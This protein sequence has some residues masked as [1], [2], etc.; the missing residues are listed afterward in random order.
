MKVLS[1]GLVINSVGVI[2]TSFITF[3]TVPLFTN[4][5]GIEE[6][7][8]FT[9]WLVS[10]NL[11]QCLD[12]GL[13]TT[14]I[15]SKKK[16]GYT[17]NNYYIAKSFELVLFF[18]SVLFFFA[19]SVFNLPEGNVYER[20]IE[21]CGE[22]ALFL[23]FTPILLNNFVKFYS[24][25]MLSH[26]EMRTY[27]TFI[28]VNEFSKQIIGFLV[29]WYF[30]DWFYFFIYQCVASFCLAWFAK[31]VFYSPF[32]NKG[33]LNLRYLKA[34]VIKNY[35]FTL[36]IFFSSLAGGALS[37]IDR[38][39]LSA[40]LSLSSTGL[41]ASC[42]VVASVINMVVQPFHK[43]SMPLFVQLI[44]EKNELLSQ[45]FFSLSSL[46][47][48]I[49]V[50]LAF[51]LYYFSP[52]YIDIIVVD[53]TLHDLAGRIILMLGLSFWLISCG[54]LSSNLLQAK[55]V[56]S[57]QLWNIIMAVVIGGLIST[58]YISKGYVI[59]ATL[60]WLVHGV[61]QCTVLPINLSKRIK[62]VTLFAWYKNVLF[63]P[64]IRILLLFIFLETIVS[65]INIYVKILFT[66]LWLVIDF[67]FVI[68]KSV[69]KVLKN[70]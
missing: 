23:F 35:K 18:F 21:D 25:G 24:H 34:I 48:I 1:K 67:F 39:T 36:I 63:N 32:N 2:L 54:W 37:G 50:Y 49:T 31:M 58:Y 20:I 43:V 8:I 4:L 12:L 47:S 41:Y 68:K 9:I 64:L 26:F 6:Y 60:I 33:R 51:F 40:N 10:I 61:I 55:G 56:P 70:D 66:I 45:K 5:V 52:L 22:G 19:L 59:A 69:S 13:S 17:C 14:L 11:F 16:S 62:G 38:F 65:H 46:L 3:I 42:F 15:Q 29:Y 7:A 30:R 44:K 57:I 27:N 28:V 53:K